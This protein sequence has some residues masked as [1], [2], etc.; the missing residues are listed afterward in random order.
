MD[1]TEQYSGHDVHLGE[2]GMR[3]NDKKLEV[4]D[5]ARIRGIH[6]RYIITEF[7]IIHW[8]AEHGTCSHERRYDSMT[9]LGGIKERRRSIKRGSEST[10]KV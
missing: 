5:K 4:H 7:L 9:D 1:S 6:S 2:W 10:Y 8:A 3:G